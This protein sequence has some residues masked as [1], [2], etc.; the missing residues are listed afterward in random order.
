MCLLC[1][2]VD[3][4]GL[5]ELRGCFA[6]SLFELLGEITAVFQSYSM[7]YFRNC[8]VTPVF[9]KRESLVHTCLHDVLVRRKPGVFLDSGSECT[10]GSGHLVGQIRNFDPGI[11]QFSFNQLFQFL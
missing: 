7:R 2:G 10:F 3:M 9:Q 8:Q 6:E 1:E 4:F 11:G 5:K